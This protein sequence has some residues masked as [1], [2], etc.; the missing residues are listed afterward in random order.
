MFSP[1]SGVQEI[2]TEHGQDKGFYSSAVGSFQMGELV[3]K[4]GGVKKAKHKNNKLAI[5]T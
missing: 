4:I 1:N 5:T 3:G 2:S